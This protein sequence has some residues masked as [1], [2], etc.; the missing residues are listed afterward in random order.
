MVQKESIV[1]VADNSGAREAKVISIPG[2]SKTRY[3]KIGDIVV[4][5]I[6]KTIPNTGVKDHELYKA[7]VVRTKKEL[8][9]KDGTYVRFDD[10]AVVLVDPKNKTPKGTRIFGPVARELREGGFDK[11]LSLAPEVL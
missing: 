6:Q 8:R 10:N 2:A 1:K 11:I 9:R 4:V 5:S 7:V 3:A